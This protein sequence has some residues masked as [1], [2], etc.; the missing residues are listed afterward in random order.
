MEKV[1][2]VPRALEPGAYG[3]GASVGPFHK[4]FAGGFDPLFGG[5]QDFFLGLEVEIDDAP[6]PEDAQ[7]FDA[8]LPAPVTG[9]GQ[10]VGGGLGVGGEDL[11]ARRGIDAD[12]WIRMRR[13]RSRTKRGRCA[14]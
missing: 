8:G 14:R 1:V 6:I 9:A 3:E 12:P 5:R 10:G 11:I 13:Q 7:T 2:E 4:A